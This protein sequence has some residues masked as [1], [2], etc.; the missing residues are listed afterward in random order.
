MTA[1]VMDGTVLQREITVAI[2]AAITD[3]PPPCLATVVVGDNPRCHIFARDKRAAAA[4]AGLRTVSVDLTGAATQDAVEGALARLA[5]DPAVDGVFLQLPVPTHIGLD[6][7]VTLV[8]PAKDVDGMG[9]DSPH[10]PTSSLA[11]VR[12][13]ERYEI[14][15][16]GRQVVV[17]GHQRGIELLLADRGAEV[18][19]THEAASA[20]CRQA[21]ILVAAA[22]RPRTI[23]ADHVR[24]GAAVVDVT[25]DVDPG[26]VQAVAGAVAPYPAA[27]GPVAVACLL[28]NTLDAS[29][30]RPRPRR[31]QSA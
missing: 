27:V 19:V 15:I 31:G 8:P 17:V 13:L 23:G 2:R 26:P 30:A 14:P 18:T 7:I 21:D 28:A 6:R 25:G 3:D 12:L 20:V 22:G 10:A 24:P 9:D 16:A 5:G 1:L 4:E 29:R 11:V